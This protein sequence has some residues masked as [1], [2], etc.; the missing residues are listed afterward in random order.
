MAHVFEACSNCGAPVS[1]SADGRHVECRFCGSSDLLRIDPAA[2]AASLRDGLAS[3]ADLLEHVAG[4]LHGSFP[5]ET[6]LEMSGFFLTAKRLA[7]LELNLGEA[8]FR[9]RRDGKRLVSERETYVRGIRLKSE[10]LTP[11]AWLVELFATLESASAESTR[12]RD[13][14]RRLAG[15]P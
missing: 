13:A 5:D 14:L 15:R 3:E 6:R 7:V 9:M 4:I 2:L 10:R 11:D 12:A 8:V 1:H